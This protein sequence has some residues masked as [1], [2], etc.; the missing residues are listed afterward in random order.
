V[1][2]IGDAISNGMAKME[3]GDGK[4]SNMDGCSTCGM[5]ASI[6]TVGN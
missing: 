6:F 4:T 3:D 5:G 2:E 1:I